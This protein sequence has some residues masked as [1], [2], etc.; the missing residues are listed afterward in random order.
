LK[1]FGLNLTGQRSTRYEN[2]THEAKILM[3]DGADL[4]N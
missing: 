4:W 3:A 1:Y 2:M